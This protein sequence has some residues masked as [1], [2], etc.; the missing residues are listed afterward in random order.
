M[1]KTIKKK[2]DND[3]TQIVEVTKPFKGENLWGKVVEFNI[4]DQFEIIDYIPENNYNSEKDYIIA[5]NEAKIS[6]Y[7]PINRVDR[8]TKLVKE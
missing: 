4:G 1:K 3:E 5:Y 7:I 2:L 8:N 6:C